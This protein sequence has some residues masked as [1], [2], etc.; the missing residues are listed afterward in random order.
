M[1]IRILIHTNEWHAAAAAA[2]AAASAE[3]AFDIVNCDGFA[4]VIA[5]DGSCRFYVNFAS[6]A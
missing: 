2:S 5:L 3:P 6:I 1:K 4:V